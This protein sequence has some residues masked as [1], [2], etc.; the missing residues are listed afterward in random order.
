MWGG[1]LDQTEGMFPQNDSK[2]WLVLSNTLPNILIS[3]VCVLHAQQSDLRSDLGLICIS[4]PC[5]LLYEF[6]YEVIRN[7]NSLTYIFHV[8]LADIEG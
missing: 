2:L 6:A 3:K 8:Q 7:S 1:A 4:M 5:N